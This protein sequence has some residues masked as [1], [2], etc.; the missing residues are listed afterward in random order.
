[1]S[2][3][4][5]F[6]EI[7]DFFIMYETHLTPLPV[8]DNRRISVH[9]VFIANAERGKTSMGWFYGFRLHLIINDSG[10]LLSFLFTPANTVFY[11]FLSSCWCQGVF[12]GSWKTASGFCD[13]IWPHKEYQVCRWDTSE[14]YREV[15]D[16]WARVRKRLTNNPIAMGRTIPSHLTP[17]FFKVFTIK[18]LAKG[19]QDMIY[20]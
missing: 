14:V 2:I 17:I 1:M 10:E 6:C 19:M 3:V 18:K 16:W 13:R 11:F 7:H 9:R 15:W 5:L 4:S 8:C 12:I 20:Y